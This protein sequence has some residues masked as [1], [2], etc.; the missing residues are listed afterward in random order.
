MDPSSLIFVAL[1]V[2]WAVYLIPKALEHHDESLRSRA[3]SSFSRS[4]RV[5]ARREPS[6]DS[7]QATDLVKSGRRGGRGAEPQ[8]VPQAAEPTAE[9][10]RAPR[11][12]Y[13]EVP[14]RLTAAQLRVRRAAAKR[15][16][17]RRRN[18]LSALLLALV[19]VAVLAIVGM[20]GRIWLAAPVVLLGAWLAACRV[21]V[22]KERG[23]V[24][25]R[26]PRSTTGP[27]PVAVE[28]DDD[29][30]EIVPVHDGALPDDVPAETEASVDEPAMASSSHGRW[31]PVE[32][33]LPTYVSKPAAPRRSVR[34]IDLDSTGVWSSGR[35]A[36]DSAL[37]R[38][39][40]ESEREARAARSERERRRATGS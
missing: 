11:V 40:E 38:E 20:V 18:V 25:M 12:E 2:A 16:T 35:N 32:A 21:M 7:G 9:P 28:I 24:T 13:A 29:T 15:A 17:K 3:V 23:V 19:V 30:G 37:A 33:P 14:V 26:V 4:V 27:V 34:T 6:S 1:F 36:S 5:L 10:A 8:A 31:D 39:A 22:K